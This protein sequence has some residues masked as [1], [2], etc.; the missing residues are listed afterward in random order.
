VIARSHDVY[1]PIEQLVA[2]LASDAKASG[3]ILGVGDD[4]VDGMVF[5]QARQSALDDIPPGTADDV[6]NEQNA[7]RPDHEPQQ[8]QRPQDPSDRTLAGWLAVNRLSRWRRRCELESLGPGVR[9]FSGA[10]G[11]ARR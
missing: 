2:D 7:H 3:G 4:D 10:R 6:T 1:A 8:P 11:G 9:Q 5:D